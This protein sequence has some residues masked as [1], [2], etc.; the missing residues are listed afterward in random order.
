MTNEEREAIAETID[1]ALAASHEAIQARKEALALLETLKL[2]LIDFEKHYLTK[3]AE[4]N[5]PDDREREAQTAT[6]RKLKAI[7]GRLR[8]AD[9]EQSKKK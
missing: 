1:L 2:Y 3:L 6:A 4:A 7:S 8:K 9:N 5:V